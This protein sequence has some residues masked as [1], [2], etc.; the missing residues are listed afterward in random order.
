MATDEV[1]IIL[2]GSSKQLEASLK[3]IEAGLRR[4]GVASATTNKAIQ[5]GNR[6]SAKSIDN[7]NK[8]LTLMV[9]K[10]ALVAFAV[11]TLGNIFNATFGA[12][13]RNIDDFQ[14][15]AIG[16]AAAVTSLTEAGDRGIGDI[17][18]QN[19]AAAVRVFEELEL[20]AAR[21]FSTGQELQLGFNTLAQKGVVVREEEFNILGK[22][23]D[24]IKLLTGGQNSQIQIQQ[25]LRAILDGN[26]RTTT[27]FGKSLQQ[28]GVD[29]NQLSREIRATGSIQVFEQ[30]LTG[31]DA[32]GGAIRRTLTSVLATFKS[33]ASILGRRVFQD[34]FDGVVGTITNINN[35]LID[36]L[37]TIVEIGRGIS[38]NIVSAFNGAVEVAKQFGSLIVDI[39]S[40]DVAKLVIAI[41][42]VSVALSTGPLGFVLAIAAA[43]TLLTG[44]VE[45]FGVV[46]E[47]A[48]SAFRITLK[49]AN[50][51]LQDFFN[52]IKSLT[53]LGRLLATGD[54]DIVSAFF[55]VQKAQGALE[56]IRSDILSVQELLAKG[57]DISA[58]RRRDLNKRLETL[59]K[60]EQ[61][62]LSNLEAAQQ[63]FTGSE[64][65]QDFIAS[66]AERAESSVGTLADALKRVRDELKQVEGGVGLKQFGGQIDGII[67]KLKELG[68]EVQTAVGGEFTTPR[69][70]VVSDTRFEQAQLKAQRD[71]ADRLTKE[72]DTIRKATEAKELQSIRTAGQE[73]TKTATEVFR[74]ENALRERSLRLDQERLDQQIQQ[75]RD[76]FREDQA[77]LER[78]IAATEGPT[79]ITDSEEARVKLVQLTAKVEKEIDQLR[80]EGGKIGL[81]LDKNRLEISQ[82]IAEANRRTLRLIQDQEFALNR[83]FGS[84]T[85][86]QR[87]QRTEVQAERATS[88]FLAENPEATDQQIQDQAKNADLARIQENFR[89]QITAFTNAIDLAFTSLTNALVTG[90]FEFKDL[91]QAIA[92]DLIKAGLDGLITQIKDTVVDGLTSVFESVG[93][94]VGQ[95]LT[96]A[97]GLIL[98]VISRIGSDGDFTATGGGGGTGIDSTSAPVRG[99]IG[100]DSSL[101]IAEI[102]NGLLEALIPTNN[103]LAAIER[104]TR[105]SADLG[106]LLGNGNIN[107][108][109]DAQVNAI[110]QQQ[111]LTAP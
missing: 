37:D 9:A 105:T 98:A 51:L 23:V 64:A 50:D 5:T 59:L 22:L 83:A 101:P 58:D 57:S 24:Q 45:T 33:L 56:A 12:I 102:N 26:V 84:E 78:N 86:Q 103:I 27:A 17:F 106:A 96:L 60:R 100:G 72:I 20:V 44:E 71:Q 52:G 42:L 47:I 11:Q 7:Q 77:I 43:F 75:V 30:F 40:S 108:L 79:A 90:S 10:F 63:D 70:P 55:N 82:Q 61:E 54:F 68:V 62:T 28:R 15:A 66:E 85:N 29:I 19:L 53:K 93:Q 65:G 73:R 46:L 2:R 34:A 18:N 21:F 8:S 94:S 6:R 39:A 69:A 14:I 91:G 104:N 97:L 35:F 111:L 41:K 3:R 25:E 81:E 76:R 48:F 4:I 107:E 13:L 99:L 80:L 36:N 110:L 38:N 89:V 31:L 109:I 32:A 95:A 92:K 49:I 74:A 88:D 87:A 67:D 16:T 1:R